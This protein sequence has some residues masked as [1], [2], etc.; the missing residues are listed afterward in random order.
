MRGSH[1]VT[2]TSWSTRDTRVLAVGLSPSQVCVGGTLL[3]SVG[4]SVDV[5][6]SWA[7]NAGRAGTLGILRYQ[8]AGTAR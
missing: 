7:G 8:S 5:K 1:L 3:A 4:V 6:T 2:D